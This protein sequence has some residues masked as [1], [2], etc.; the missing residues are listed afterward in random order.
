MSVW[1]PVPLLAFTHSSPVGVS[2]SPFFSDS[3]GSRSASPSSQ[4]RR[5]PARARLPA[6]RCAPVIA[7]VGDLN[8]P[9]NG[10]LKGMPAECVPHEFAGMTR[11]PAGGW[12]LKLSQGNPLMDLRCGRV[13]VTKPYTSV[14]LWGRQTPRWW[15]TGNRQT[16]KPNQTKLEISCLALLILQCHF[17]RRHDSF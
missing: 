4:D 10:P 17:R 13:D 5:F 9:L 15:P 3:F 14:G 6:P 11:R 16:C 8:G 1:R 7:D 2:P 12:M